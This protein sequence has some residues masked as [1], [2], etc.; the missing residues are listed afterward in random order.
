MY[1]KIKVSYTTRKPIAWE[2]AVVE[3]YE[4]AVVHCD[5]CNTTEGGYSTL[6]IGET[7]DMH[8]CMSCSPLVGRIVHAALEKDRK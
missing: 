3:E 2:E 5:V 6:Y 1:K 8:F 7:D 4:E